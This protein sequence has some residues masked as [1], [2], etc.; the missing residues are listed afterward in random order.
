MLLFWCFVPVLCDGNISISEIV[1]L[2]SVFWTGNRE[3]EL[4]C[5][6]M[7]LLHDFYCGPR[8][9]NCLIYVYLLPCWCGPVFSIWFYIGLSSSVQ[10]VGGFVWA[11]PL[12]GK[13]TCAVDK[14]LMH[15]LSPQKTLCIDLVFFE[16]ISLNWTT[17]AIQIL[18]K[19]VLH[20]T[21]DELQMLVVLCFSFGTLLSV[22]HSYYPYWIWDL[23][24]DR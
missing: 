20:R 19:L 12:L 6:A 9:F 18:C 7:S 1:F 23:V 8:V 10:L 2:F 24:L 5:S 15:R 16:S 4:G 22:C 21:T 17:E 13:V 11:L 14:Q 3:L